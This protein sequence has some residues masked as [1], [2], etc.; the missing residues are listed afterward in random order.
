MLLMKLKSFKRFLIILLTII[1]ILPVKAEEKIDIWKKFCFLGTLEVV[2]EV[3]EE[4]APIT[5]AL[6]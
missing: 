1:S 5:E 3:Q 2:D 4:E 6:I